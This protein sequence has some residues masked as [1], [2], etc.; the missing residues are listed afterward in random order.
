MATASLTPGGIQ[1][2][3]VWMLL[4]VLNTKINPPPDA[5]HSEGKGHQEMLHPVVRA[6]GTGQQGGKA[7]AAQNQSHQG[8]LCK[9]CSLMSSS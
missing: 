4:A 6:Q 1:C 9:A 5:S 8:L 2:V 3:K 7:P